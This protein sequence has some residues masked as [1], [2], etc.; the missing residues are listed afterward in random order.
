MFI[1]ELGS[2][3]QINSVIIDFFRKKH[4]KDIVWKEELESLEVQKELLAKTV[5]SKLVL[6][7]HIDISYQRRF[8]KCLMHYLDTINATI[9]E[10]LYKAFGRLYSGK[11]EKY[12]HVFYPIFEIDK[13]DSLTEVNTIILKESIN[14]ISNGTTGLITWQASQALADWAIKT[15]LEN[16][17]ILELGSGVGLAGLAVSSLTPCNKYIFTDCHSDVLSLLKYNVKHNCDEIL[18]DEKNPEEDMIFSGSVKD[19][20]VEV[21]KLD[22]EW[23][24]EGICNEIGPVDLIFAADVIYDEF[25]HLPLI[26]TIRM[27]LENGTKAAIIAFVERNEETVRVFRE[28]LATMDLKIKDLEIVEPN[29]LSWKTP[30]IIHII[31]VTIH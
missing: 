4:V 18:V 6:E 26:N 24:R 9:D 22:W 1:L 23:L 5:N 19:C 13:L 16:K 29:Y 21:R 2:T 11:E 25:L 7:C 31:E 10:T 15:S 14:I 28:K 8:L 12:Y 27:F 17:T 30:P 3:K 20:K